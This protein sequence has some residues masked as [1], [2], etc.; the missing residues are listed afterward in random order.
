MRSISKVRDQVIAQI[1]RRNAASPE[2]VKNEIQAFGNNK[3]VAAFVY[4]MVADLIGTSVF[5]LR[6]QDQMRFYFE[7]QEPQDSKVK[8][9][10]LLQDLEHFV[11]HFSDKKKWDA[12][13]G[14]GGIPKNEDE[15]YFV[16][17]K[18]TLQSFANWFI[19]LLKE[20][21][22]TDPK[23]IPYEFRHKE[24]K[25]HFQDILTSLPSA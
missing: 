12:A 7:P 15:W 25:Q 14:A 4:S 1:G 18:M 3:D 19:G 9:T 13:Y 8:Y 5:N 11:P 16:L 22:L 17:K 10:V 6:S 23:S 24:T 20:R 21:F 2:V